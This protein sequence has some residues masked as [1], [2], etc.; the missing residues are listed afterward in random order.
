MRRREFVT[1]LSGAAV[2]WPLA[3]LAQQPSKSPTIG[4]LGSATASTQSQRYLGFVE[5]LGE[6]GWIEG[7]NIA[8]EYRWAEGRP[9]RY[10]EIATEFVRMQVDV[11]VTSG[12]GAVIAAK[13]ATSAIPISGQPT[14][15]KALS[16]ARF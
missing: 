5:R 2:T 12:T 7:R 13:Q 4:F 15:V 3:A 9:E 1:L 11:I 16:N 10:T 8:I 14:W 6:L